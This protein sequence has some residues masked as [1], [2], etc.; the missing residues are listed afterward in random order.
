MTRI[1]KVFLSE[2]FGELRV[3]CEDNKFFFCAIDVCKALGYTNI[4]RELN[5]HCRQDG[6]KSGR[7]EVAGI[8]RIVKFISEGNVYRL[9]CRS[10][11]PEAEQ[12]ENWVF[13]ELL[14]TIRVDG[15]TGALLT[16]SE[17]Q[18]STRKVYIV[19]N[20]Y[21]NENIGEFNSIGVCGAH[22]TLDA[23]MKA[24]DK[25]F[26]EDKENGCH[27]DTIPF[28]M[29]DCSA[30]DESPEYVIGEMEENGYESFHNFYAV[31][32]MDIAT[33]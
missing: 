18:S 19:L 5:I 20:H 8:P 7:V 17:T 26:A 21:S 4:T 27:H 31:F 29:D 11:K 16:L 9:I 33:E 30:F 32:A 23:A 3:I 1:P 12:F 6:I 24:A 14:P 10:N 25:L 15:A 13:D 22:L 2:M 28:T